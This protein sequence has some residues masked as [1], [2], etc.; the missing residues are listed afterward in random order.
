MSGNSAGTVISA[1]F[2]FSTPSVQNHSTISRL[3]GA[4]NNTGY[5]TTATSLSISYNS[6]NSDTVVA[7]C[8]LGNATSFIS[9]ITDSGS[10]W[11]FRAF[12][13]NGTSVRTEIWSTNAGGSVACHIVTIHTSGGTP[14]SCALE[15]YAG[16]LSIGATAVNQATSGT[17]SVTLATQD[18]N[19]YAVAGLGANSYFGYNLS[20]GAVRQAGGL[21]SNPGNNY[22]EMDLCDNTAATATSVTCS[23]V[24]GSSPWAIATLELRSASH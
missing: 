14:A 20:N 24:S 21:T 7:V 16:V 18:A 3:G 6:S 9:S 5:S 22:V 17:M 15:E 19:N 8:A 12:A 10:A 11:S 1:N 13:I 4:H 2:T 23:S